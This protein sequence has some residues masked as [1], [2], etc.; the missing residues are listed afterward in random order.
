MSMRPGSECVK[1]RLRILFRGL[2]FVVLALVHEVNH[3][4]FSLNLQSTVRLTED[5]GLEIL[6]AQ[7]CLRHS[8]QMC[9]K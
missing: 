7:S 5:A 3:D 6:E 4:L 9:C 8:S 1:Q 2:A